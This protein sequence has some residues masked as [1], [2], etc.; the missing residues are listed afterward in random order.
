MSSEE[1]YLKMFYI[2]RWQH[3]QLLLHTVFCIIKTTDQTAGKQ[4]MTSDIYRS[5]IGTQEMGGIR[6]M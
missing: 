6:V 3:R 2:N 1:K 4:V 5:R